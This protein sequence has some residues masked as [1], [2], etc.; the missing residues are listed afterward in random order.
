[1]WKWYESVIEEIR[2]VDL[3]IPVLFRM[4]GSLEGVES[5]W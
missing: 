2:A 1:M 3:E 5:G 4:D